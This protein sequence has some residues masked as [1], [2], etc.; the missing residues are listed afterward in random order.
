MRVLRLARLNADSCKQLLAEKGV[1]GSATEQAQL[2]E[3]Y[4]GN[5][6]ALKIVAQTILDL[7]DG[8]IALFLDDG[9]R[10]FVALNHK[11]NTGRILNGTVSNNFGNGTR[12]LPVNGWFL[13]VQR[14]DGKK[15]AGGKEGQ[16]G[17][18]GAV[19]RPAYP[20]PIVEEFAVNG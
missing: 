10:F 6:L 7:F 1:A 16:V 18:A 4:A 2:I 17:K 8:Q 20:K 12:C 14:H 15:Q 9:E 19:G 5:P 13:A 3:A 11:F